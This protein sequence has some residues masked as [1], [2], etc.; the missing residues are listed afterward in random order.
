MGITWRQ[1]KKHHRLDHIRK[2]ALKYISDAHVISTPDNSNHRCKMRFS[3][4]HNNDKNK[5]KVMRF[6][7]QMPKDP[8]VR[9]T[10]QQKIAD[11]LPPTYTIPDS[12][13]MMNII[14][15]LFA[16][17]KKAHEIR[18]NMAHHQ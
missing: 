13:E 9:E 4:I 3:F 15:L 5:G 18:N 7:T 2:S 1:S 8:N 11:Q 12:Q 16:T 17:L 6:N 10:F 14:Q